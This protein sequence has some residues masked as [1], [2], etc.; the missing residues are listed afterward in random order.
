MKKITIILWIVMLLAACSPCQLT[1]VNPV[2]VYDR[3]SASA[4]L[5]GT[6]DAGEAIQPQVKTADGFY[7][8][9]PGVAQAG[10]VG[11]FRNR[12]IL[13]TY[14]VE[15]SGNC[16]Q[17]DTVVGPITNLCYVMSMGDTPV[18]TDAD[19]GS[20]LVTTLHV[21]D[22]VQALG[23]SSGWV[24]IDLNVGS[25]NINSLGWVQE[26]GIGYNGGCEGG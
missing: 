20:A 14:Q 18:Y 25:T 4:D 13:K 3:P 7:G 23:T 12:W 2:T 17:V 8:F 19:T 15:L 10:N 9:D 16:S 21:G 1:P 24:Q 26:G 6:L 22:Y 5:F 11:I